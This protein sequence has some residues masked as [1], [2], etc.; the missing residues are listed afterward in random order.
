MS[1]RETGGDDSGRD[2][3]DRGDSLVRP[4]GGGQAERPIAL[5]EVES[6]WHNDAGPDRAQGEGLYRPGL[7]PGDA[8]GEA[9]MPKPLVGRN[10]HAVHLP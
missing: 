5:R 10:R 8:S 4:I 3:F 6:C 7:P 1:D 9:R 2:D